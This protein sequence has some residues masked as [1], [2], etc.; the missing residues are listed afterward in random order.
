[1][2]TD[3]RL[4]GEVSSP[5]PLLD[6]VDPLGMTGVSRA[7]G[8]ARSP[9]TASLNLSLQR[10]DAVGRYVVLERLGAGG[11]GVVY[12]AY[13]P[14]L[15]RKIALKLLHTDSAPGTE[16]PVRGRLLR[17]AQAMARLSHPHVI[18]VHDVGT[19]GDEVF[20]AMEFV[21]GSTLSEWLRGRPPLPE[22]LDIFLSAGRGL[23]AAHAAG[24]VHRDF[25]PD[26]VL[27][28][29]DGRVCVADFG[30]ARPQ[31]PSLSSASSG[32]APA[33]VEPAA[34]P[35]APAETAAPIAALEALLSGPEGRRALFPLTRTGLMM[36]T[37]AYMSP[38]QF[39]GLLADA[40]TDQFSFCVAL[41]EAVYGERPFAGDNMVHLSQRV[42]A[43]QIEPPPRDSRVPAWLR[44]LLLRGLSTRPEYRFPSMEALLL[45][46]NRGVEHRPR[47]Q[48]LVAAMGSVLLITGTLWYSHYRGTQIDPCGGAELR[49]AGIWDDPRKDQVKAAFSATNTPYAGHA[50]STAAASLDAYAQAWTSTYTE[51]CRATRQRGEQSEELLDLRMQCLSD[52]LKELEALAI[53]FTKADK[54][55]VEKALL[56]TQGLSGLDLCS[57]TRSL[58]SQ[59]RPPADPTTRARVEA[60]RADLATAKAMKHAGKFPDG[61][62][63]AEAAQ[64]TAASLGY[65]P[66]EAEALYLLGDIQGEAGDLRGA[67]KNLSEAV[68]AAEAGHHEKVAARAAAR[69]VQIVGSFEARYKEGRQWARHAA[70]YIE[71]VGGDE[72][73]EAKLHNCL[74]VLSSAEGNYDEALD[75]HLKALAL[76]ERLNGPDHPV[77]AESLNNL[78][79]VY[80]QKGK[81]DESL[82]AHE[83]A[84]AIWKKAL[85]PEH[86]QVARCLDN[87][88]QELLARGEKDAA[89]LDI[90]QA[91]RIREKSLGP[92]HPD[93]ALSKLHLGEALKA[94]GRYQEAVGPIEG[95]LT[96]FEK[97][98]GPRHPRVVEA[99]VNEGEVYLGLSQM[100]KA[101]ALLQRARTLCLEGVCDPGQEGRIDGLLPA[102]PSDHRHRTTRPPPITR[103]SR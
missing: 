86:P 9:H 87:I 89:L 34:T 54:T 67:E 2:P 1:M 101:R 88:G 100:Q 50:F 29:K 17:E 61:L 11:M 21:D 57:D 82:R 27:L 64:A 68:W 77:V 51:A 93:V 3:D 7:A 73:L 40:R 80:R 92:E 76:R 74:G 95:A 8:R 25:K 103:P 78:G 46:L 97:A 4:S 96:L 60:V 23:A 30:L 31:P 16:S 19:F 56:A 49:L 63:L 33:P 10:G 12:A 84:L 75:H 79:E 18:T 99:L 42:L 26:N 44:R 43:G 32:S 45:S 38:E 72:Q 35:P 47:R 39:L 65:R 14:E 5:F 66:I 85:G 13:D 22:I 90:E 15:D 81:K 102:P 37:P 62:R 71:G 52:H 41:Y 70:A 24:L 20:V 53:L 83:R 28:G 94:L 98:L 6:E 36:G 58:R 59:V 91:L 69:L 55:I 48:R